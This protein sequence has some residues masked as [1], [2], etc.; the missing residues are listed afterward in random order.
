MVGELLADIVAEFGS[1]WTFILSFLVILMGWIVYNVTSASQFDPFPFVFL[2]LI[3]SCISAL[4]APILMMSQA[5]QNEKDR[6]LMKKDYDIGRDTVKEL[7]E[8]S[9]QLRALARYMDSN[10]DEDGGQG[11]K[12]SRTSKKENMED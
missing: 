4:Q 2:N 6:I 10:E 9:T 1:S 8:I 5:R 3:L 7:R 12:A 11:G